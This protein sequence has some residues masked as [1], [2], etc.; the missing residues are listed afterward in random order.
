LS[1]TGAYDF[2]QS[3]VQTLA[4]FLAAIDAHRSWNPS[5]RSGTGAT[6]RHGRMDQ[7]NKA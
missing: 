4:A 7:P 6:E 2:R 1:T 3:M 5:A